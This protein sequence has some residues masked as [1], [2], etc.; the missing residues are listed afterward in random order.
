[1]IL[2]RPEIRTLITRGTLG[3][4]AIVAS[5]NIDFRALGGK[6]KKEKKEKHAAPSAL[7]RDRNDIVFYHR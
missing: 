4:P 3:A 6:K 2:K 7:A 5:L 1:V